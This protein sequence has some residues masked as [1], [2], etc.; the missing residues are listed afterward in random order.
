MKMH[1]GNQKDVWSGRRRTRQVYEAAKTGQKDG[2][3]N[4]LTTAFNDNSEQKV[5][6]ENRKLEN[7]EESII[8][9][10]R[11]IRN[12]EKTHH[13]REGGENFIRQNRK[14]VKGNKKSKKIAKEGET[15]QWK[16]N[17][18]LNRIKMDEKRNKTE[19]VERE[20]VG[21]RHLERGRVKI[22]IESSDEMEYSQEE[23]FRRKHFKRGHSSKGTKQGRKGGR[24]KTH[25]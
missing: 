15:R 3:L 14:R 23:G 9:G 24:W 17:Q 5:R 11:E 10:V 20:E 7:I 21:D 16:Q 25:E 18:R 19:Q 1:N 8:Q 4:S 6:G 12:G 2:S 22:E 13:K